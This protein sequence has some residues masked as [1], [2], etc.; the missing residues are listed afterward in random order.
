MAINSRLIIIALL[1]LLGVGLMVKI[2]FATADIGRHIKNGEIILTGSSAERNALLTTNFYSYTERDVPFINHHWLSGVVFFVIFKSL[3]S[4]GLS[5]FYIA[6]MLAAFWLILDLARK[7]INLFALGAVAL[8]AVPIITSRAEIRPEMF[9]FF[10]IALYVW[11]LAK[12]SEGRLSVRWL[13]FLSLVQILWVNLHIGFIFGPFIIGAYLAGALVEKDFALFKRY[14]LVLLVTCLA[15]L[16]NPAHIYGVLYPFQI[17]GI[18]TYRIFENQSISFLT[19]LGVGNPFT[20]SAYRVFITIVLISYILAAIKNW[21]KIS[22]PLL[23]CAAVFGYMGW[24]AVRDFPLFALV[25]LI[26]VAMNMEIIFSDDNR[27]NWLKNEIFVTFVGIILVFTGLILNIGHMSSHGDSFGIGA[28]D[29]INKA[30]EFF[31][32]NSLKGPI[33]NNYDIGGYLIYNVFPSEKVYFDNRPEAYSKRFVDEEYIKALEEP[34]VFDEIDKKYKFNAIFFYYRDYT[35]WG[36]AFITKKVFDP[37]WA[38]VYAD[39]SIIILLKRNSL[40]LPVIEK[41]EVSRNS[42]R[43]TQ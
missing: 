32:N 35:P 23:I 33:F 27:H 14:A 13:W 4:V 9:T 2:D 7:K 40:N 36:Q 28:E 17:F 25:G 15:S 8:I 24:S 16:L 11:I 1:V 31:R 34:E 26:A 10:F 20:F 42:F 37:D 22:L 38:P 43:I 3:G 21:K 6:G 5:L 30:G 12:Y 19:N 29:G 41:Y 39:H 18:Y